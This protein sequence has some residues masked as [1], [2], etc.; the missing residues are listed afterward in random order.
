LG[1][2]DKNAFLGPA[3]I[4]GRAP[5]GGR[6]PGPV[7]RQSASEHC[8]EAALRVAA[9][10]VQTKAGLLFSPLWYSL[11]RRNFRV[12]C[13]KLLLMEETTK[14]FKMGHSDLEP[15]AFSFCAGIALAFEALG[16]ELER[17]HS[18][19]REAELSDGRSLIRRSLCEID[20]QYGD[21]RFDRFDGLPTD[22]PRA[23]RL[24]VARAPLQAENR[25]TLSLDAW[26]SPTP[27]RPG[28]HADVSVG[29]DDM[30]AESVARRVM[31]RQMTAQQVLEVLDRGVPSA[32]AIELRAKHGTRTFDVQRDA[33]SL[34]C[35]RSA[36]AMAIRLW[37]PCVAIGVLGAAVPQILLFAVH[38][39]NGGL[40]Q[41]SLAYVSPLWL[42][43]WI[44]VGYWLFAGVLLLWYASMQRE[45]AWMALKQVST[46]WIVA[47]TG[48]FVAGLIS[49]QEFGVHRSTWVVLPVYIACALLF[50]LAAMADALPPKVRLRV[51]RVGAPFG[52]GCMTIIAVVLRL[53]TAEGTPG[54]LVWT[55]MGTDTVTN[56][57]AI[58]YSATVMALLLAKGALRAWMFPDQLAFIQT[59]LCVA[60]LAADAAVSWGPRA[61]PTAVALPGASASVAPHPLDPSA[62]Q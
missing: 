43:V 42:E 3:S 36:A 16:A 55:V 14:T 59:S 52:V 39:A 47:M 11:F 10:E 37:W 61:P 54:K 56:L 17:L 1:L 12:R 26:D 46:M 22:R 50:P 38:W 53:P 2:I 62:L 30:D 23:E 28:S 58:T 57:Q 27:R 49:H 19:A 18:A 31:S 13:S 24:N 32:M 44:C 8:A 41:F 33:A 5:A 40:G 15:A 6:N 21:V 35:C 25:T 45:I 9:G 29:T 20:A 48:V 7:A 4:K 34:V 51:L 60:E